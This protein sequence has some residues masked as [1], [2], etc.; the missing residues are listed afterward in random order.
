MLKF[1]YIKVRSSLLCK[2]IQHRLAVRYLFRYGTSVTSSGVKQ[3]Q[4]NVL[5]V[6]SGFRHGVKEIFARL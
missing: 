4:K 5:W 6:I 2:C 1:Q 3:S